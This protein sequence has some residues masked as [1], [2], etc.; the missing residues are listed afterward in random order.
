MKKSVFL[1]TILSFFTVLVFAQDN[2]AAKNDSIVFDKLEHDYGT[3]EKGG[4][5]NCVFT[6]T[7]RG[8]KPLVLSNVRAPADVRYRNGHANQLHLAKKA[9]LK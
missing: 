4:D 8:Q 6:F 1:L 5:G 7:N 3:I 2:Q 9:K